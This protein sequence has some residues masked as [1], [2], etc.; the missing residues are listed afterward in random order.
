MKDGPFRCVGKIIRAGKTAV[1]VEIEFY[2]KNNVLGA[3]AL[4]TW[5][6]LRGRSVS[7]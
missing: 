3:K 1:V 2:D 7:K 6:I 5:Y 4:G